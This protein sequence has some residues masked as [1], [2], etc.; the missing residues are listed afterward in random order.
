MKR[1]YN[2]GIT[3]T[4]NEWDDLNKWRK[5][6]GLNNKSELGRWMLQILGIIKIEKDPSKLSCSICEK[7]LD[8]EEFLTMENG[9]LV[10]KYCQIYYPIIKKF[11]ERRK[12]YD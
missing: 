3:L 1:N 11:I 12:K 9:T 10:C 7:P 8:N 2:Y 6:Y 4:K 5:K